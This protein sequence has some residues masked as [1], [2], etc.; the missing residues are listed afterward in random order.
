MEYYILLPGD[1]IENIDYD[2]HKLGEQSFNVFWAGEGLKALM[3]LSKKFPDRLEEVR[4]I[5][6]KTNEHTVE[7]FLKIIDRLQIRVQN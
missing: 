6:S 5:D 2:A 4:I 1:K 7:E 3:N